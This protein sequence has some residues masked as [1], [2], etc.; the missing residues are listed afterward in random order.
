MNSNYFNV[1]FGLI[2][3]N[4]LNKYWDY[5][6]IIDNKTHKKSSFKVWFRV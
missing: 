2:A 3:K 6:S 5:K 1:Y 4:Y